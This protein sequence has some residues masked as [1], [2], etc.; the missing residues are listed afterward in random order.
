MKN[1]NEEFQFVVN[2]TIDNAINNYFQ[3]YEKLYPQIEDC[4]VTINLTSYSKESQENEKT[5]C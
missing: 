4:N 2:K 1:L 3:N 5:K